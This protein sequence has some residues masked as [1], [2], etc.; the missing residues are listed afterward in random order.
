MKTLIASLCL[1]GLTTV[2]L[3]ADDAPAADDA[4]TEES[5]PDCSEIEDAEKKAECEASRSPAPDEGK[6][7]KGKGLKKS[8]DNKMEKF[9]EE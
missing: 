4:A 2:A 1:L 7:G 3:A 9:D 8:D 5:P 6:A